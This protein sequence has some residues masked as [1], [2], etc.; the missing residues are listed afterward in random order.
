MSFIKNNF[1]FNRFSLIIGA[2]I[3]DLI[4][5]ILLFLGLSSGRSISHSI[6]F[7]VLSFLVIYAISKGNKAISISFLI[8]IISH[9]LL[10]LP[11]VPFFYPF[12]QYDY[13]I[14]EEPFW[15]WLTNFFSNPI[16]F[17]TEILGI[18]ILVFIFF[19]NKLYNLKAISNF[20]LKKNNTEVILS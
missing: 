15:Y 17:T 20:L 10:D 18:A 11:E 12:I 16:V 19:K 9:L 8:G 4:D 14:L 6:L 2:L 3:S 7:T 13:E 1:E 5:K